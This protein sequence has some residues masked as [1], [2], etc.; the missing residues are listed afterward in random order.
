[1]QNASE[2]SGQ[3]A[4]PI[5][6]AR[7]PGKPREP[8]T[9]AEESLPNVDSEVEQRVG[10]EEA[11]LVHALREEVE[12]HHR[13]R[14]RHVTDS[15]AGTPQTS[16]FTTMTGTFAFKMSVC[17]TLPRMALPTGERRRAPMT[18]TSAPTLSVSSRIFSATSVSPT[19]R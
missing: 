4:H 9:D 15:Q 19:S 3:C 17:A 11:A 13:R 7:R 2:T 6:I 5:N 14:P 8:K 16:G 10:S 1:M 18:S 12:R